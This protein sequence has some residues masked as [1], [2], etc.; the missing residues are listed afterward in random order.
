MNRQACLT[1]LDE[2]AFTLLEIL[3]VLLIV[4]FLVAASLHRLDV[5]VGKHARMA[6]HSGVA[7]L[8]CREKM[9]WARVKLGDKGWRNDQILFSQLDTDLG[10]EFQWKNKAPAVGGGRLLF[11]NKSEFVLKRQ[12]STD[13]S[14]GRWVVHEQ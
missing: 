14:P 2:R 10:K 8:N 3:A 4:G 11:Q 6:V 5:L 7:E 9:L 12:V 13:E 1:D